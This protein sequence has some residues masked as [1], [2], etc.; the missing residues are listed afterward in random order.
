[1]IFGRSLRRWVCDRLGHDRELLGSTRARCRRC[2]NV[3]PLNK[4]GGMAPLSEEFMDEAD[5]DPT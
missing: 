5:P 3:R 4:L 2:G 1:M